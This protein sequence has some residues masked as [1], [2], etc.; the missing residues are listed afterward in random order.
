MDGLGGGREVLVLQGVSIRSR[1][2]SSPCLQCMERMDVMLRVVMLG[3]TDCRVTGFFSGR[4]PAPALALAKT[5]DYGVDEQGK[6]RV[7]AGARKRWRNNG[8]SYCANSFYSNF[9]HDDPFSSLLGVTREAVNGHQITW[10]V[11]RPFM[12][13]GRDER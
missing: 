1:G 4:A 12:A 9:L 8:A 13:Y 7:W 11:S 2:T 3:V 5:A 10:G 6:E